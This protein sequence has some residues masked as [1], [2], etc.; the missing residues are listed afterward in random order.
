MVDAKVPCIE[1]DMV[2]ECMIAAIEDYKA[3][4]EALPQKIIVY[5]KGESEAQVSNIRQ[6]EVEGCWEAF[7][8]FHRQDGGTWQPDEFAY[9]MHNKHSGFKFTT[10]KKT[11]PP[12]GTFII[13][14]ELFPKYQFSLQS[15]QTELAAIRAPLYTVVNGEQMFDDEVGTTA[16]TSWQELIELSYQLS[17]LFTNWAG[18]H[19]VPAVAK[20]ALEAA[21]RIGD[22]GLEDQE[23][24]NFVE[25]VRRT[26]MRF[27]EEGR[28]PPN[29]YL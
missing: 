9:V 16:F 12:L 26:N 8:E 13:G 18:M 5:R 24:G 4:R 23:Y 15:H 3:K 29:Y 7:T 10:K 14:G 11:N 20:Y 28:P 2:R 22:L 19:P 21:K 17:G 25:T 1:L 27:G 6:E